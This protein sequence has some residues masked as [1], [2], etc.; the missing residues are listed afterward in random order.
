MTL[1]SSL[2][3]V[4]A[5]AWSMA[6][7]CEYNGSPIHSRLSPA[8]LKS[9]VEA[10]WK[11][12][13]APQDAALAARRAGL[14]VYRVPASGHQRITTNTRLLLT[15]ITRPGLHGIALAPGYHGDDMFWLFFSFAQGQGLSSVRL[16]WPKPGDYSGG[17]EHRVVMGRQEPTP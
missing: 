14:K 5:V 3:A 13:M 11:L 16:E 9:R 6:A 12:G 7:G 2:L 15:Q 8:E 17:R 1:L 4:I 10:R